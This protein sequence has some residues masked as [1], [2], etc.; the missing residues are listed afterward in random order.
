M[1][2]RIS[3]LL[4]GRG[5]LISALIL[6][7]AVLAAGYLLFDDFEVGE[8]IQH[9]GEIAALAGEEPL[10]VFAV[11]TAIY[12]FLVVLLLPGVPLLSIPLGLVLGWGM[13][14][15]VVTCATAIGISILYGLTV[16]VLPDRFGNGRSSRLDRL[17]RGLR[18]DAVGYMLFLRLMPPVPFT[19]L[20]VALPTLRVPYL[21]FL[22]TTI[23]GMLP[24]VV[25]YCFVGEGL[26]GVV[27]ERIR[28]CAVEVP[29]CTP[30]FSPEDFVTME[31]VLATGLLALV[32]LAPLVSRRIA[33]ARGRGAEKR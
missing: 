4:R 19:L 25:V 8:L 6:L 26:R 9:Y 16:W 5:W 14:I 15:L 1:L 13:A 3:A 7:L 11:A 33:R 23:V 30:D 2:K 27:D 29:P 12:T 22:L 32:S 24:R 31:I 18:D 21:Q 17:A 28:L 10:A 20:N